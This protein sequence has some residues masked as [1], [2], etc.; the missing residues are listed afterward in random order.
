MAALEWRIREDVPTNL[1]A[2][3][4]AALTVGYKGDMA[5]RR[6]RIPQPARTRRRQPVVAKALAAQPMPRQPMVTAKLAS[7]PGADWGDDE[8]MAAYLKKDS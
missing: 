6:L 8:T 3:K 7:Y 2:V 4:H 5:E 1:R